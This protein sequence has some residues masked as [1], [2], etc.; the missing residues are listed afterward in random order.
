MRKKKRIA[1]LKD[2]AKSGRIKGVVIAVDET[3]YWSED[4]QK[5][6]NGPI[7]CLY[8]IDLT[9]PTHCC[10]IEVNYPRYFITNQFSNISAWQDADGNWLPGGDTELTELESNS[11]D[12]TV[13]YVLE[14]TTCAIV[15]TVKPSKRLIADVGHDEWLENIREYYQGNT[16]WAPWMSSSN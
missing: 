5:K 12:E 9:Q 1:R 6:A 11:G 7:Y 3:E 16:P 13:S 4:I 8:F 2:L 14:N 15:E 10:S